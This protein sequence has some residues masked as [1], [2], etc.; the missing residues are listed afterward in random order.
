MECTDCG[1]KVKKIKVELF[2]KLITP[3]RY[4]ECWSK[5]YL[6]SVPEVPWVVDAKRVSSI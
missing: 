5:L 3:Q 4:D 1:V 6:A 2:D